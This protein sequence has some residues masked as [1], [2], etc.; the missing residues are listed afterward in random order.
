MSQR[1]WPSAVLKTITDRKMFSLTQ[2]S[3]RIA[4]KRTRRTNVLNTPSLKKKMTLI[5]SRA[6]DCLLVQNWTELSSNRDITNNS[7]FAC[8]L[9][10]YP[11]LPPQLVN[12]L[13]AKFF[14]VSMQSVN[15]YFAQARTAVLGPYLESDTMWRRFHSMREWKALWNLNLHLNT[16]SATVYSSFCCGYKTMH[17][18]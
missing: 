7:V 2:S 4:A 12:S 18:A 15:K 10:F 13:T 1:K 17:Q 3:K 9:I 5:I 14:T 6:T 11:L 16:I 8:P